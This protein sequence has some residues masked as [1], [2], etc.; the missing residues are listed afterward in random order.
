M[1]PAEAAREVALAFGCA[2]TAACDLVADAF[3]KFA[4]LLEKGSPGRACSYCDGTGIVPG[5]EGQVWTKGRG[6][7]DSEAV[8]P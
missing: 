8:A 7:H 3:D 6:W 2:G 4:D 1:T 5:S